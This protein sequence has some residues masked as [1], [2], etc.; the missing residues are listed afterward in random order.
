VQF[1]AGDTPVPP[2]AANPGRPLSSLL[3][4]HV[5]AMREADQQ[6]PPEQQTPVDDSHLASERGASQYI[7]AVMA[8]L[9]PQPAAAAR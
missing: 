7:R 8:K 3:R 5:L 2:D 4:E 1:G 6:F 9:H